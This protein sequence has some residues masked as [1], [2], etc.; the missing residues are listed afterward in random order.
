MSS[1]AHSPPRQRWPGAQ[2]APPPHWQAPPELQP[3]ARSGSHATHAAAPVAHVVV[4]GGL[5]V[6]P[7]QQ[8]EGQVAA[9]QP[10]QTPPVQVWPAGHC[11]HAAPATAHAD[12]VVPGRHWSPSQQPAHDRASHTHAPLSQRCPVP[13]A[14]PVPQRHTPS[15]EHMFAFCGSHVTHATPSSPHADSAWGRHVWFGAAPAQQPFGHDCAS[16][17]HAPATHRRPVPHDGPAPHLQPPA[18]QPSAFD[19]SQAR[20]AWPDI[21][22]VSAD[23][24]RQVVPVQ[25]P[26]GQVVTLHDAHAPDRH[27][28]A[29]GH[30]SH[31]EPAVPHAPATSPG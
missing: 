13:H 19:G 11:W 4:D 26:E 10:L 9:V 8:P 23:G 14:G 2:A 25:Q 15:L 20:H 17:T 7:E 28:C 24:A 3:S 5:H 12:A 30:C 6:V 16:H 29:P 1:H 22:H 31:E 18:A 27:A 21:P